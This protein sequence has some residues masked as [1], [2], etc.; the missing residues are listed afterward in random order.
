MTAESTTTGQVERSLDPRL[1]LPAL[2]VWLPIPLFLAAIIVLKIPEPIGPFSHPYLLLGLNFIFSLIA[3]VFVI[4]LLDRVFLLRGKP[5]LLLFGCGLTAWALAGVVAVSIAMIE[6]GT[7]DF[8]NIVV[9]VHN[10]CVFVSALCNLAGAI[11]SLRPLPQFRRTR[12]WLA[13]ANAA[14][15]GLVGII[16]IAAIKEWTPA[17]FIEDLGGTITR[18]ELMFVSVLL[19]ACAAVLI[20]RTRWRNLSEFGAWYAAAMG[21]IAVGLLGVTLQHVFDGALSWVGRSAQYLGGVYFIIAGIVAIRKAGAWSASHRMSDWEQP[22]AVWDYRLLRFLS[23]E[24]LYQIP[25]IGRY[26]LALLL[27]VVATI[28]RWALIPLI[29]II[30]PFPIVIAAVVST[31]VLLG[32]G[33]GLLVAFIGCFSVEILIEGSF[34]HLNAST[35]LRLVISIA[36]GAFICITFHAIRLAKSRS[37][38]SEARLAGFAA[39]TFE[40]IVESESGFIVDCNEQFA[41]MFGYPASDLKG[42]HVAD[43]VAP[44]DRDRVFA[45]IDP[46]SESVIEHGGLRADGTRIV[47]EVHGK[48]A[49]PRH[50]RRFSAVRDI[51]ERKR[52][53]AFLSLSEERYRSLFSGMTEGFALHAIITD[54][55]GRPQ[56]YRFL[57]ANKAFERL[58][59]LKRADFI[60]RR[61]LEILPATEPFWIETYGRVALTGEPVHF[62]KFFPPL[63][64]W[65]RVYAYQPSEG[66]FA[67]IFSDLTEQMRTEAALDSM[68]KKHAL[69]FNMT[70]DGVW[71]HNLDGR[72]LEA[73][74]AYCRMSGYSREE[75]IG[76]PISQLEINESPEEIAARI[77]TILSGEGHDRFESRHRRKDGS[78]FDV[79]I[80]A[81]YIPINGGEMAIFVRD[82]TDRKRLEAELR[83]NE[84]RRKV[85]EAVAA[86]RKRFYDVLE[87][88][89]P[90]ICLLKRDY[91]VAFTNRSFREKFGESNGRHCYEYCYGKSAPCDFCESFN[92]FKTGQSHSWE[93]TT[94]DGC[95]IEAHDYPF[96][97][98][99][100]T[101][102]IL[103]MDLDVTESR[104]AQQ[105]LNSAHENLAA[106]ATQLRA[107]AG[108]LT[109]TEQRERRRM[110]KVLHDHLQQ[111]LVGA[112]FR[113]TILGRAGDDVVQEG[114]REVEALLD[115]CILASR[116]LIAELSPPILH[117]AGL[118]A[119]L[120]WLAR[121][122]AD[123]HGLFVELE[124]E[125]AG[126]RLSEDVRLLLFESV[127]ELL[128]NTVKHSHTRSAAVS[129]RYVDGQIQV[130]VSDQGA[131]F[132]PK[133]VPPVGAQ[134]AGFG[135]FSIH[136]RL[137]LI[138][139][140]LEIYSSPGKGS[141]FVLVAPAGQAPSLTSEAKGAGP[142]RET[143]EAQTRTPLPG[144]KIQVLLA[145]DHVVMREG[146]GRLL[147]QESDIQIIG[148]AADGQEAVDLAGKLLPDVILMDMS[149]PKL[150]G[151]E[152]ARAIHHDY[153]DIC[154]IGLS[155]FEEVERAQALRAAGAV[156]Y[157]TKS[158]PSSDLVT[159]I[160]NAVAPKRM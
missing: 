98:A 85:A 4:A 9:T 15:V 65:Y 149:M 64:R 68:A 131:G 124:L 22:L 151:V 121:W 125:E 63:N 1:K 126:K 35:I 115:E 34:E 146:L 39:A 144:T 79:D 129:V 41:R 137:D 40:G 87:T 135:L 61:V 80:T 72:I 100:G 88:L 38:R 67:V 76:M 11:I 117:E 99:D 91:H 20:G 111:L 52:T 101:E 24:Y 21:L 47:V 133:T 89:S 153:P 81:L 107:L 12:L 55:Q 29:G 73:N 56:D 5:D 92:V 26:G 71:V 60:G 109:L 90:M 130:V 106:R 141:R 48:P 69:M 158:G 23:P 10:L 119:G 95:I 46:N 58:T 93:V 49:S 70:A 108:E 140:R 96:T 27:V 16:V 7:A 148:E 2:L 134:G 136:E 37:D 83:E 62:E 13:G 8:D 105:E 154:I 147:S 28:L 32:F 112:K 156:A 74:N 123:K 132:D 18:Q 152:A 51:T 143:L 54:E 66:R 86:E 33:P 127:R 77:R 120:E 50:S 160:R 57:E 114:A 43:L 94:A 139:G 30:D 122:M 31:V 19:F 128:F 75:M 110:A 138:G 157:L 45:N 59:G 104:R 142:I 6:G 53:E 97:D 78:V 155:M 14:I 118:N 17:F 103:E 113:V 159:A 42:K 3:T 145:D 44:E 84:A 36:V 116:S 102:M 150:N 25:A 82:I